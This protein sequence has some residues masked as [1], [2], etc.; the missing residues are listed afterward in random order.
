MNRAKRM[1]Y[2]AGIALGS[3]TGV[4]LAQQPQMDQ[5]PQPPSEAARPQADKGG[6]EPTKTVAQ[7]THMT[8]MVKKVDMKKRE[9]TLTDDTGN[10]MVVQ[11][12][13]DVTRLDQVKKG[14]RLNLDYY[15]SVALSLKKPGEA[16]SPVEAKIVERNEGALPGGIVARKI[17]ATAQVLKVNPAENKLT[18]KG[19]NG[20]V[21]T[22]NV[23]DPD[24]QTDLHKLKKGDQ[25]EVTYSQALA[26][27]VMPKDKEK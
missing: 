10:Q 15:Q 4:A 8:A 1:F 5:P 2:V 14:D 13:E 17:T 22:I 20:A 23:S 25:I 27:S 12:P 26:A 9:L 24:V 6:Q 19:P 7:L 21:D 3:W 11:V 18:I 16:S